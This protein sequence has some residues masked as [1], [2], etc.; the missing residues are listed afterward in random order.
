[1]PEITGLPAALPRN[2]LLPK[3][4]GFVYGSVL[5]FK[6]PVGG[7]P[8]SLALPGFIRDPINMLALPK[9]AYEGRIAEADMV[10]EAL[11]AALN[12]LGGGTAVG[13][14][15]VGALGT[16]RGWHGTPHRFEPV[17]HN[18]FGEFRDKAIGTG[19]GAQVYGYGH[20]VAGKQETA[21]YYR[22]ALTRDNQYHDITLDGKS[23]R[24]I[25]NSPDFRQ[26]SPEERAALQTLHDSGIADQ[27]NLSEL[28]NTYAGEQQGAYAYDGPGLN[29]T[30][31][32]LK[33]AQVHEWLMGN[34]DRLQQVEGPG[35]GTLLD[36]LIRPDEHELLSWDLPLSHQPAALA[37][38]QKL[39]ANGEHY[40]G[41]VAEGATGEQLYREMA[42]NVGEVQAS[43]MLSE[44]GIP[45]IRYWDQLSRTPEVRYRFEGDSREAESAAARGVEV[46]NNYVK[47]VDFKS[48][49]DPKA[50]FEAVKARM[51]GKIQLAQ[52]QLQ[53]RVFA[54]PEREL[55]IK[56]QL[57]DWQG[58]MKNLMSL[59]PS[60]LEFKEQ[61]H[62]YVI[63]D[64]KDLFIR[65]RNGE[66][67]VPVDHDP[68]THQPVEHDPFG[69][70]PSK[71]TK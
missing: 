41:M 7:G 3:D 46:I 21:E 10:P 22:D 23:L 71:I 15:P 8:L 18:P 58:Q 26:R 70:Q 14:A 55:Q 60:A 9:Q 40:E 67:F 69:P 20:Y 48:P 5:P 36:V 27:M 62:N 12:L 57:D 29:E 25:V 56:N 47:S 16:I 42:Q 30:D 44:A 24:D 59:D 6:T 38:L 31:P 17:E 32:K 50:L 39:A 52:V 45:G 54:T 33:N 13:G 65:G 34:K 68:W 51:E 4:P 2:D 37:A 66:E 49:D 61:S 63:F 53:N 35:E 43:K 11:G 28:Y 1:M 19:E 64:P